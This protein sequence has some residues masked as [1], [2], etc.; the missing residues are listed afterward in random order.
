VLEVIAGWRGS[1]GQ[2]R[3]LFWVEMCRLTAIE[4]FLKLE[5]T[6]LVFRRVVEEKERRG[7]EGEGLS[8]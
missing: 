4:G 3:C 8:A 7:K 5:Y 1:D 2:N 6:R